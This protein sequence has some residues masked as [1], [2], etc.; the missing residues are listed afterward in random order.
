[1]RNHWTWLLVLLFASATHAQEFKWVDKDGKTRYGDFPPAG[2][3]ATPLKAP[4]S[5]SAAVA[6]DAAP[7][8]AKKGPLTAAEKEQDY[9]NRQKEATKAKEKSAQDAQAQA[10][11]KDSCERTQEY[12]RTLEGGQRVAR[13]DAKGE[14]YFLDENQ[15]AQEVAKARQAAQEACK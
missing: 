3:K 6:P 11:K 13:T 5:G 9:R 15:V 7:K 14:R 4:A 2:V 12:L 10:A 1:M 8:D